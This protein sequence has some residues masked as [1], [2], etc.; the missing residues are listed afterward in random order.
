MM[1]LPADPHIGDEA[2]YRELLTRAC[3]RSV[4]GGLVTIGVTPTRPETGYGYIES[5]ERAQQRRAQGRSASSRSR[6]CSARKSS[7]TTK[8]FLW[9]SGMFFFRADAVLAEFQRQ[10]AG[11]VRVRARLVASRPRRAVAHSYVIARY[12]ELTS[13]LDRPRH[14]GESPG[15][16]RGARRVRL[17]RHR[18]LDHAPGS[19][20]RRTP[21]GNALFGETS[22]RRC[23]QRYVRANAGKLVALIGVEDLVVVDTEDALLIMPRERAQDVRRV[24]DD[25]KASETRKSTC[26]GT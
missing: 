24:V 14:H 6:T 4:D 23:E 12:G 1:V 21:Q 7:C 13:S 26:E 22:P 5:G 3:G 19:S 10:L 25:S 9:N 15:R 2:A 17:V 8:R 16:A 18:Q 11:P 20:P